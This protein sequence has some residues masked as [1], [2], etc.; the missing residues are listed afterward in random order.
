MNRTLI[1]FCGMTHTDDVKFA[2][3]ADIDFI[4]LI[5]VKESPRCLNLHQAEKLINACKNKKP[6]VGIF[7]NQTKAFINN[8]IDNISIDF[9]QFHGDEPE[10][11]CKDFNKKYF[12][13]I[14]ITNTIN[15]DIKHKD[16]ASAFI[17]DNQKDDSSS[18]GK[19]FDWKM[20]ENNMDLIELK[21]NN[22]FIAGGLNPDNIKKLIIKHQPKGLDV[23]SGIEHSIGKKD[24]NLMKKFIENVRISE[25]ESYEKNRL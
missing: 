19:T 7:M 8:I 2:S 5:F 4:G 16:S 23:S 3:D 12:K 22:Y 20:L 24:F 21:K 18:S 15:Y 9:L 11:F 6:T 25:K 13:T 1:K 14:S 10:E 17:I